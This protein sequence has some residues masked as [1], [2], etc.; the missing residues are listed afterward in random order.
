M[1]TL[2]TRYRGWLL[3]ETATDYYCACRGAER[4]LVGSAKRLHMAELVSRFRHAVDRRMVAEAGL[5][6]GEGVR[7][8]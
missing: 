3:V 2:T 1:S 7:E 4:V 5:R 8:D 6:R